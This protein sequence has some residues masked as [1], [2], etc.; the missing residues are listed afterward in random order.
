MNNNPF[1]IPDLM[2]MYRSVR[3]WVKEHQTSFI[4]TDNQ[5]CD[6]IWTFVYDYR[7][8]SAFEYEV[9]AVRV[10]SHDSLQILY[11]PSN[12][13]YNDI[14]IGCTADEYWHDVLD[15]DYVY[16]NPTIFNIAEFIREYVE[17]EK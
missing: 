12:E 4:L 3:D 9:K 16:F 6:T 17:T 11:A 13:R 5:D 2:P 8:N 10:D 15:D 14:D 1:N 7:A